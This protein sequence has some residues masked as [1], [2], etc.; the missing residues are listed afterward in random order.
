M[1]RT[2]TPAARRR[3]Q[4]APVPVVDDP[5][6]DTETE[7]E[8]H[9]VGNISGERLLSFIERIERLNEEKKTL[10][11][12]I[13]EIKAEAKGS[14]FDIAVV[15]HIIKERAK[16]RDD[17]DEFYTTVDLYRRAIGEV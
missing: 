7:E 13:K 3:Q 8:T 10:S 6:L 17:L 16:D 12:D 15:N 4:I 1:A 2:M 11:A 9:V 5:D 14:G